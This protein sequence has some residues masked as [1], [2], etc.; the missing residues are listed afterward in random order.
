MI[1]QINDIYNQINDS[2]KISQKTLSEQINQ[3]ESKYTDLFDYP[4]FENQLNNK[5]LPKAIKIGD[6]LITNQDNNIK[7]PAYIPFDRNICFNT[8][9]NNTQQIHNQMELIVLGILRSLLRKLLNIVIVDIGIGKSNF[10]ILTE[11]ELPNEQIKIIRKKEQLIKEIALLNEH[12]EKID[13]HYTKNKYADLND[14][15]KQNEYPEPF[16]I[17]L[18][19]NFPNGFIDIS[20]NQ[21][22]SV[23]AD[24]V[25]KTNYAGIYFLISYNEAIID[26]ANENERYNK[27]KYSVLKEIPKSLVNISVNA[28]KLEINGISNTNFNITANNYLFDF[29][30]YNQSAIDKLVANINE[31]QKNSNQ[32]NIYFS[33]PIGLIGNKPFNFELGKEGTHH[34]LMCGGNGS[35]KT[36]FTRNLICNLAENYSPDLLRLYII[37]LKG[38]DYPPFIDHPNVEYLLSGAAE[39]QISL[40]L[41]ILNKAKNELNER[42]IKFGTIATNLQSYNKSTKEPLPRIIIIIEEFQELYRAKP[43]EVNEINSIFDYIARQG[44]AFGINLFL[45]TQNL[46]SIGMLASVRDEIP[47]SIAF[48]MKDYSNILEYRPQIAE[49]HC[50]VDYWGGQNKTGHYHLRV[51][52]KL[53]KADKN[54]EIETLKQHIQLIAQSSFNKFCFKL[55]LKNDFSC[56][57]KQNQNEIEIDTKTKLIEQ[58]LL[59]ISNTIVSQG[60]SFDFLN[61]LQFDEEVD[62]QFLDKMT[63]EEKELFKNL[64]INFRTLKKKMDKVKDDKLFNS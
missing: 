54:N 63:I 43:K 58:E 46:K 1:N 13:K 19:S 21:T 62:K 2:V 55:F 47:I 49:H 31:N 3:F 15:N 37:D 17:V 40:A 4:L 35:G 20:N 30:N 61:K 50:I 24:I 9:Q 34:V 51:L 18:I 53:P 45:N 64:K 6:Y 27:D 48:R 36:T 42:K 22:N 41:Q 44:R 56:F 14:Y 57:D 39:N 38:V 32:Q 29:E 23:F 33:V 60:K 59:N 10:H 26:F 11:L 25:K 5:T 12:A 16:T 52:D 8:N 7:L 28:N